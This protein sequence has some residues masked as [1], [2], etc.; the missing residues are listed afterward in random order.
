[1]HRNSHRHTFMK[2]FE[3]NM[4]GRD[5]IVGDLHGCYDE[6]QNLL[7]HVKFDKSKDRLFSTGDL[8]DRGPKS[9][10]CVTLLAQPWFY[11]VLG[12]H[13]DLILGKLETIEEF[14]NT[15]ESEIPEE[16]QIEDEEKLYLRDF[17]PYRQK[18]LD[19]PLVIEIEHPLYNKIYIVH[20]E[21]LPEHLNRFSANPE[22]KDDYAK[23]YAAMQRF[24]FT[25]KIAE[26]FTK[27]KGELLDYSLKQKLLWSR[28][29]VSGFYTRFEKEILSGDFQSIHKSRIDTEVKIFCGHNVVPFPMKIGLQYYI[30]TGA[31]LGHTKKDS[32]LNIFSK[33]GSEFFSLTLVDMTLGTCYCYVTSGAKKGK[34]MRLQDSLYDMPKE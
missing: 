13:E 32:T 3:A 20:A 18:M 25:P 24:D 27:L 2:S 11:P 7:K 23:Y 15:P 12:N 30:D 16:F 10:E 5:F 28:K 19:M 33:F 31:A 26:F 4:D 34:I 14:Q 9:L 29:N 6:L 22:Q 17:T 21:V 8:M 1:M